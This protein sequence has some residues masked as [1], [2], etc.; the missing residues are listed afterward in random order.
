MDRPPHLPVTPGAVPLHLAPGIPQPYQL[1]FLTLEQGLGQ[2]EKTL[3]MGLS[4][5]GVFCLALRAGVGMGTESC[6][7]GCPA[8]SW[9]G[10]LIRG[11]LAEWQGEWSEP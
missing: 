5:K 4:G 7:G 9:S 1:H 6:T 10:R 11:T 2:R 8:W 3:A